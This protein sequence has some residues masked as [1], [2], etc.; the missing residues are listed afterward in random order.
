MYLSIF[1][2]AVEGGYKACVFGFPA[3]TAVAPTR[4]EA[5]EQARLEALDWFV[6]GEIVQV[7]VDDPD[8]ALRENGDSLAEEGAYKDFV[9][10]IREYQRHLKAKKG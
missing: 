5:I 2:K 6:N 10:K 1:V 8:W 4:D 3:C 7:E 9:N